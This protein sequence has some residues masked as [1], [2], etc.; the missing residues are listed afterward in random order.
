MKSV[1]HFYDTKEADKGI[2]CG[3]HTS[4]RRVRISWNP[5]FFCLVKQFPCPR[6]PLVKPHSIKATKCTERQIPAKKYSIDG[7]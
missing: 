1:I 3:M 2:C 7:Q 4:Q 5:Y 6:D